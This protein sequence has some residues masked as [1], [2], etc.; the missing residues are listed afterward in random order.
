MVRLLAFSDLAER[1]VPFSRQH[2]W[3]LIN[4]KRIPDEKR[5]P[6]PVKLGSNTNRWVESEVDDWLRA[7]I[8]R[9]DAAKPIEP[10]G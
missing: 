6:A 5:F 9:R 3:R 7:Q 8:E 1:G 10:V 2:L 4:D